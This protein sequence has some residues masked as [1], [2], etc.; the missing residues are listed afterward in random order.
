MVKTNPTSEK[1]SP[2][3]QTSGDGLQKA[4][5][6]VGR[7]R[8]GESERW[9]SRLLLHV[10]LVLRRSHLHF[11][12]LAQCAAWAH[13]AC[14]IETRLLAKR[15]VASCSR[16]RKTPWS[17]TRA[18]FARS[19]RNVMMW[20]LQS[21][22]ILASQRHPW[23]RRAR[24]HG[25]NEFGTGQAGKLISG[26]RRSKSSGREDA[27]PEISFVVMLVCWV[28]WRLCCR[29][30]RPK[31]ERSPIHTI[32]KRENPPRRASGGEFS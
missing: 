17:E 13:P 15:M 32:R 18:S 16:Y 2:R 8:S 30:Q 29:R 11:S 24:Q 3:L 5:G 4:L 20:P 22:K 31:E 6:T 7:R 19:L 23:A 10:M 27:L 1:D 28:V 9:S 12:E 25:L 14:G 26:L 21:S